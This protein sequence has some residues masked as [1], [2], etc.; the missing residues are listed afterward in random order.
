M[1]G[2]KTHCVPLTGRMIKLL[3]ALPRD[4][5]DLVFIGSKAGKVLG[6]MAL[7]NVIDAMGHDVTVHGFRAS[8]KTWATEQTS[9]P[10]EVIEFC[11]AHVVGGTSE[12]VYWRGDMIERRR[13]LM[14]A[15]SAYVGTVR[16]AANIVTPLRKAG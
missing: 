10:S 5:G 3:K 11:L 13:T 12:Q 14:D 15:W 4:G 6:K 16:G 8:F 7:P 2:R 1:K 9:Y